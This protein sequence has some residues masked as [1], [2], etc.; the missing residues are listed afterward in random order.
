MVRWQCLSHRNCPE[1]SFCECVTLA[2]LEKLL[3]HFLSL[4]R[5]HGC[6]HA[7]HQSM[8]PLPG[9]RTGSLGLSSEA[10]VVLLNWCSWPQGAALRF[11]N[12]QEASPLPPCW[13]WF[14]TPIPSLWPQ[15]AQRGRSSPGFPRQLPDRGGGVGGGILG[16]AARTG[17]PST[18][19]I[20]PAGIAFLTKLGSDLPPR[21]S[22]F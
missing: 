18:I 1:A 2:P 14:P 20:C 22:L 19:P 12:K 6:S 16:P 3:L 7:G 4:P 15:L 8:A 9:W 11:T 21:G 17:S 10:R 13:G 5:W